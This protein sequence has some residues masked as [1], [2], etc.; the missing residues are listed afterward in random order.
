MV[1]VHCGLWAKCTKLWPLKSKNTADVCLELALW[2][3]GYRELTAVEFGSLKNWTKC[4]HVN[5][6]LAQFEGATSWKGAWV[7]GADVRPTYGAFPVW[8]TFANDPPYVENWFHFSFSSFSLHTVI[9]KYKILHPID[10]QNYIR[11]YGEALKSPF[12]R[13][14]VSS[15]GIHSSKLQFSRPYLQLQITFFYFQLRFEYSSPNLRL[16]NWTF[17]ITDPNTDFESR[18]LSMYIKGLKI[19]KK[20]NKNKKNRKNKTKQ[21]QKRQK[22]KKKKKH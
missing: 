11:V 1:T 3:R 13:L 14:P 18:N 16:S 17:P 5:W 15:Q 10:V 4:C 8:L 20:K 19:K 12:S 9:K 21:K 2:S 22:K 6:I 7:R